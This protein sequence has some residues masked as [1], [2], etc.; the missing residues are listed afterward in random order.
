MRK[1]NK[2]IRFGYWAL[3]GLALFLFISGLFL[4]PVNAQTNS[5]PTLTWNQTEIPNWGQITFDSLP[6]IGQSGQFYVSPDLFQQ[7]KNHTFREWQEGTPIAQ[8]LTLGDFRQTFRLQQR[9]LAEIAEKSNVNL[10]KV[11]L[12]H[13]GLIRFQTLKSLIRAVPGLADFPLSQIPP[14]YDLL[15]SKLSRSAANLNLR[16]ASSYRGQ[17][18]TYAP[19]S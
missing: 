9:N 14:V 17:L 4:G 19:L 5:V 15:I 1:I 3:T 13:F 11:S 6:P 10:T 8:V 12:A 16:P 18:V 7:Y 2:K